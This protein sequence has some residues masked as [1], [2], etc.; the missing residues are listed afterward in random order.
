MSLG[1]YHSIGQG[2]SIGVTG[3]GNLSSL[4]VDHATFGPGYQAG[5]FAELML[6]PRMGIQT[7][8]LYTMQSS[9]VADQP[10]EFQYVNI[11]ILLRFNLTKNINFQI[12]PQYN[13]LLESQNATEE[14]G[15]IID[16]ENLY[17]VVGLGVDMPMGVN[18]SLRFINGMSEFGDS[19]GEVTSNMVQLSIGLPILQFRKKPRR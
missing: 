15:G 8:V 19:T 3:G 18:A 17:L 2:L 14:L 16:H 11:P 6:L 4:N 12:G 13:M 9:E 5:G 1:C 10:Y 7:E